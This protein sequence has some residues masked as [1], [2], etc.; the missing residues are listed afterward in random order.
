MKK[1]LI[2]IIS[3]V[4]I[5]ALLCVIFLPGIFAYIKCKK[6]CPS[7]NVQ[8][9]DFTQY[10]VSSPSDSN[11]V[12]IEGELGNYTLSIPK[13]FTRISDNSF[14]IDNGEKN[15]PTILAFDIMLDEPL[16]TFELAES[17]N[18]PENKL[19][20]YYAAIG[21]KTPQNKCERECMVLGTTWDDFKIWNPRAVKIFKLNAEAKQKI[22]SG[23]EVFNTT[24]KFF[25]YE[26]D[27]VI[28]YI[29]V[30]YNQNGLCRTF[31]VLFDKNDTYK[32]TAFFVK[33]LDI[34]TAFGILNSLKI[35]N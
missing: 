28:G 21:E 18:I 3:V 26:N 35:Q 15:K 19:D 25:W 11:T 9:Q 10:D 24:D 16:D 8:F 27:I 34:E 2:I 13:E 31:C 1:K 33:S 29:S 12:V 4:S 22:F 20:K 5:I 7:L 30:T 17:L 14:E 6:E 32:G 23:S